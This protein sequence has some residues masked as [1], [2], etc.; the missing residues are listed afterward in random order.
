MQPIDFYKLTRP[1][2]ERFIGSVNGSGLPAPILRTN[3]PPRAPLV[4]LG[5]SAIELLLFAVVFRLG[6]GDLT[7]AVPVPGAP[8]LIGHTAL[9]ALAVFGVIR[10]FAIWGERQRS[11]FRRGIYVFPVGLIDAREAVLRLYPI[12]D[13][14][15]VLEPSRSA[16]TLQFGS[17]SFGFTVKDAAQAE[18]AKTALASARRK[19][20]DADADRESARPKALAALDPLQ[21]FANPLVSSDPIA[22]SSPGWAQQG[23]AI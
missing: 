21:G 20:R 8:W 7:S 12:E 16:F 6:F 15:N 23:W 18:S 10:A 1:V 3:A 2:Q 19:G 17:K 4:W 14:A 9:L 13:L 22:R 5:V 11:P